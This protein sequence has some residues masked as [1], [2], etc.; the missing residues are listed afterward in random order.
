MQ[1]LKEQSVI[2]QLD[3]QNGLT[4]TMGF[5]I[6]VERAAQLVESLQGETVEQIASMIRSMWPNE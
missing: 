1:D 5:R 6:A 4:Y 2:E 3:R